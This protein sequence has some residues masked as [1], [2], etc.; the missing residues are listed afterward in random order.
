MRKSLG[1]MKA[2]EAVALRWYSTERSGITTA[3]EFGIGTLPADFH[4]SG[5]VYSGTDHRIQVPKVPKMPLLTNKVCVASFIS[6]GDNIQYAQRAM[7]RIWDRAASVRGKAP[8]NWTI[9]P[10]LVDIGP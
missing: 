8:L 5:S 4:L 3:S 2:G 10:G 1:N 7:K 9:A 6:D